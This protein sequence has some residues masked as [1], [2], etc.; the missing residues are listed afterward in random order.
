LACYES[1]Y[2]VAPNLAKWWSGLVLVMHRKILGQAGNQVLRLTQ[3]A[4]R[5]LVPRAY[6][7]NTDLNAG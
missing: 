4:L 7:T 2:A 1:R 5:A 6:K 3:R